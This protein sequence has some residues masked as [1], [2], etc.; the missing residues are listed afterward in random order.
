V[1]SATDIPLTE[2]GVAQGNAVGKALA[3]A[4]I[5][6]DKI[7]SAPL[8]RTARL[9][10]ARRPPVRRRTGMRRPVRRQSGGSPR[11]HHPRRGSA[12]RGAP[13][14]PPKWE[15]RESRPRRPRRARGSPW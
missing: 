2:N 12:H 14:P 5:N 3:A 6:V 11:C 13:L 10:E 8:L 1:G 4:G 7:F 9:P 15:R